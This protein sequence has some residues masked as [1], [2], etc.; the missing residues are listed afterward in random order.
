MMAEDVSSSSADLTS[1]SVTPQHLNILTLFP[2]AVMPYFGLG[3]TGRAIERELIKVEC[4]NFRMFAEGRYQSVDDVPFGGGA[5]MVIK[6]E[7]VARALDT[8]AAKD[9]LGTV[10]LTAPSGKVFTQRD[11]ERLS[12]EPHLTFICGRYEGIDARLNIEYVNETFSIGDYVLSGGELAA[13]VM[14]DA[15]ARLRP[16]VL[17]NADSTVYESHSLSSQEL[18]ECPHYTRPATW[19]GHQVPP[20]LLSGHHARIQSWRRQESIKHTAQVRPELLTNI[21]LTSEEQAL[22]VQ[23]TEE[24]KNHELA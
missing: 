22:V 18:L 7:P 4:L 23:L 15:L 13:M 10:I 19:R 1:G 2:E 8:L 21:E 5:G 16:G 3:V 24:E 20:V 17:N 14:I 11:A 9:Q 6:A 12:Q